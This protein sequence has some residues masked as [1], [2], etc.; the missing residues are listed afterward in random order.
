MCRFRDVLFAVL[1]IQLLSCRP[2]ALF[3]GRLG[4]ALRDCTLN[5]LHRISFLLAAFLSGSTPFMGTRA[6][7]LCYA[8]V[9]NCQQYSSSE[10]NQ[11]LTRHAFEPNM[12]TF[13]LCERA[14]IRRARAQV[15]N[16]HSQRISRV[17]AGKYTILCICLVRLQ[18]DGCRRRSL[19]LRMAIM[20][21]H[22][23]RILNSL[24]TVMIC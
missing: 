9:R 20:P 16:F 5:D 7:I 2:R 18:M 24:Q 12:T 1:P 17:D 3:G 23:C 19:R 10:I 8:L 21:T 15:R 22:P 11:R 13:P 4:A 6:D 14:I